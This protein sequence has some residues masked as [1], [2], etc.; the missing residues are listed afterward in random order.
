MIYLFR[1]FSSFVVVGFI[2]ACVQ[3]A[4]LIGL[5]EWAGSPA[6]AAALLGYAAGG[7][8]SY[9]LNRRHD[10]QSNAP[11]QA[12]VVRFSLVAAVGFGLTYLFMS[13]LVN[14]AGVPYLLAQAATTGTVII[15]NFTAHKMWTFSPYGDAQSNLSPSRSRSRPP[16]E[17]RQR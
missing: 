4:I 11:H 12:A 10:F 8:V 15:W 9:N 2:A 1:Q 17:G 7:M 16:R 3:F 13:L 14:G 6:V 5:V